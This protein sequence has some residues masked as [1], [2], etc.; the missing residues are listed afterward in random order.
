MRWIPAAALLLPLCA[1][2]CGRASRSE[3][4][5][6]AAAI[7]ESLL[8]EHCCSDSAIVQAVTDSAA[9]SNPANYRAFVKDL[10]YF[11]PEI[12]EAV[13]D[14]HTRSES[15]YPLPD[16]VRVTGHDRRVPADSAELMVQTLVRDDRRL[17]KHNPIVQL[18]AVGYSRD[19]KVAVVRIVVTCGKLCGDVTFRALRRHPGGWVAA[20]E[21]WSA[22]F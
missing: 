22:V 16:S 4:Q 18:S 2:G 14:L 6:E 1:G 3:S 13:A 10:Q 20:E 5:A 15:V 17:Y 7:Y 21:V 11:S 9:L 8:R 12:R 19:G